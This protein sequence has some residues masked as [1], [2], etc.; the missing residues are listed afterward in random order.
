MSIHDT[1]LWFV[2]AQAR[3]ETGGGEAEQ[4]ATQPGPGPPQQAQLDTCCT[5]RIFNS[6]LRISDIFV[7]IR[8]RGSVFKIATKKIFQKANKLLS[9][10]SKMSQCAGNREIWTRNLLWSPIF[11]CIATSQ[12]IQLFRQETPIHLESEWNFLSHPC[13]TVLQLYNTFKDWIGYFNLRILLAIVIKAAN[14]PGSWSEVFPPSFPRISS[15][16]DAKFQLNHS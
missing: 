3:G 10:R 13:C 15:H 11:M 4:R 5:V 6:V 14:V 8:I 7:R 12:P 1:V 2:C 9:P 16:S